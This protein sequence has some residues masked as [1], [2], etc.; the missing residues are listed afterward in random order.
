MAGRWRWQKE[1]RITAVVLMA[2][3]IT[4]HTVKTV[5]EK[6]TSKNKGSLAPREIFIQAGI[7]LLNKG[8]TDS[9][10][11]NEI[12]TQANK[13]RGSFYAAFGSKDVW[14][15]AL[16]RRYFQPPTD[17][18]TL[19]GEGVSSGQQDTIKAW[20]SW[21]VQRVMLAIR[22][23]DRIVSLTEMAGRCT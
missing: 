13:P 11:L 1:A 20:A 22:R 18:L 7:E 17:V 2:I 19:F 4:R 3:S 16:I 10:S 6:C 15:S 12:L 23:G 8:G 5:S 14:L 9:L 21:N